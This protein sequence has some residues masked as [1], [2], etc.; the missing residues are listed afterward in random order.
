MM[1][2]SV[3]LVVGVIVLAVFP[4]RAS[5]A[6]MMQGN[7]MGGSHHGMINLVSPADSPTQIRR[8]AIVIIGGYMIGGYMTGMMGQNPTGSGMPG[9]N[10]TPGVRVMLRLFGVMDTRGLVTGG[11]NHLILEGQLTT[12]TS[13]RSPIKIDQLFALNAGSVL[14]QV[15]LSLPS[16]SGP[17]TI[18][19]D[20]LAVQD[21]SGNAF[22]VPG[23]A[24]APP[25]PQITPSPTPGG[26]CTSD[27]D[28]NDGNPDTRDV[29]TP[30]GCRHVGMGGGP[31][32]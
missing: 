21:S 19:I 1:R 8:G 2:C 18:T 10:P 12:P 23:V 5:H 30:T 28:C 32:M 26:N 9:G 29:C 31:M 4:P 3:G 27:G 22:A 11:G 6:Q 25:T 15:P 14:V 7:G 20:R 16:V 13:N 17:A 24:I